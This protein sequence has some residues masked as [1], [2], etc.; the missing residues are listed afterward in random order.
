ML[1]IATAGWGQDSVI[2]ALKR[3][4]GE[5]QTTMKKMA[6]RI[7]QLEKE[8]TSETN[9]LGLVE[10]SVRAVQSAPSALNPAIGMAI[11]ATGEHRAKTGGEFNFR[12]AEI[13]IS[14]SV[15]PYARG[16]AFF[17]GS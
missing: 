7:E 2:E 14:A 11:D 15:D 13:G 4:M 6:E 16:Y 9:R 1:L 17:T 12:A 5:M 8:K 10:K 3:Q